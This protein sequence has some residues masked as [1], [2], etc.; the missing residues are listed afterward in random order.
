[1][2][3]LITCSLATYKG[4]LYIK[5]ERVRERERERERETWVY[6][7]QYPQM[8]YMYFCERPLEH[9]PILAQTAY[10]CPPTA[11]SEHQ[12]AKEE[13]EESRPET[14]E[15]SQLIHWPVGDCLTVFLHLR[16]HCWHETDD[17][18]DQYVRAVG[19]VMGCRKAVDLFVVH[20]RLLVALGTGDSEDAVADWRQEV[21]GSWSLAMKT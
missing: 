4:L 11:S 3:I 9:H 20:C 6:V 2:C 12:A 19:L 10:H 7:P 1:M 15:H 21:L 16:F 14:A 5:R 13:G 17:G 18:G 8:K